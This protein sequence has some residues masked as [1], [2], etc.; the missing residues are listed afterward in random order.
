M[1][2]HLQ[3]SSLIFKIILNTSQKQNTKAVYQTIRSVSPLVKG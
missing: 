3:K 2:E 1:K